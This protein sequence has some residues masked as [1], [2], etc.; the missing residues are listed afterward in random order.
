MMSDEAGAGA[1]AGAGAD[2]DDDGDNDDTCAIVVD[3]DSVD[4]NDIFI[5]DGADDGGIRVGDGVGGGGCSYCWVRPELSSISATRRNAAAV[6]RYGK[7]KGWG[8]VG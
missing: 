6:V 2:A 7:R 1:G 4:V 3:A 8:R 5:A